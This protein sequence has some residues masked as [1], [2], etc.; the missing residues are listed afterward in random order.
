MRIRR[1]L[2]ARVARRW[3]FRENDRAEIVLDA[4]TAGCFT[5]FAR[6]GRVFI[7]E[8]RAPRPTTT[9]SASPEAMADLLEGRVSGIDVWL[10]RHLNVRGSLALALKLEGLLTGPDRPAHFAKPRRIEAGGVDTFYLDA[11]RGP[12]VVLLHGLGAT[13]ASMLT[14][15]RA[16]AREHRVIAPDLPGFGDS[17]KPMRR[18][19]AGFFARWLVALLDRLGIERAHLVGNSMGGRIA[20]EVGLRAP[21][22]V[23]RLALLAPA[24]AFK[25]LRQLVPLV[26]VLRP[27]LGMMPL[28]VPRLTVTSTLRMIMA[29]SRRLAA[30]WYEAA[31]DEFLR[32]LAT[33]RGRVA[34]FSAAQQIYLDDPWGHQ[35]FWPRLSRLERPALFVWGDRDFLVPAKFA[36][37]VR[38]TLP[39]AECV[40]LEDCGHVPQFEHPDRTHELV[41]RFFRG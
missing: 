2:E 15:L 6:Q 7:N 34:F 4:G 10:D 22:R 3:P 19:H 41:R 16:L 38:Q 17:E 23:D 25:K 26:R 35:G 39:H 20:L 33:P 28:V 8:G 36:H 32:V 18:Y 31:A 30:S 5:L 40:V 9:V 11:G 37:H 27:E 29:D 1:A 21:E 12:P 24:M 13:N 14:T